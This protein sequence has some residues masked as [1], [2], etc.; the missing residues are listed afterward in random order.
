MNQPLKRAVFIFVLICAMGL[1]SALAGG[2]QWGTPVAGIA[3]G[4]TFL[5]ATLIAGIVYAETGDE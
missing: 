2:V 1:L 4:A 3:A 5:F